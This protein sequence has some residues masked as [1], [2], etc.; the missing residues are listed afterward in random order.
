MFVEL[1]YSSPGK[2]IQEK[3][4]SA[5]RKMLTESCSPPPS[6]RPLCMMFPSL[7]PC[8]L[9]VQHPLMSDN[10]WCLVFCSCVSL[11]RMMVISAISHG[12]PLRI[13]SND[14]SEYKKH[15]NHH[16]EKGKCPGKQ[17]LPSNTAF[18]N[19]SVFYR[20]MASDNRCED[21]QHELG[22]YDPTVDVYVPLDFYIRHPRGFAYVQFEDVCDAEDALHNLDRKQ[23]CGWQTEM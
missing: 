19:T 5:R 4:K 8:A 12:F 11:L 17:Q 14:N 1:C 13:N 20:N 22:H 6:D 16:V 23:I 10:M 3:M 18:W 9:T 21:L 2:L 7:C 15:E